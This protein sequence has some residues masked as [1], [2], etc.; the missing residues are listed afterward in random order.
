MPSAAWRPPER[1]RRVGGGAGEDFLEGVQAVA[2]LTPA[3][4]PGPP[5][6]A[7]ELPQDGGGPPGEVGGG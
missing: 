6:P 3:R 4:S 5:H 2:P 7:A 1:C